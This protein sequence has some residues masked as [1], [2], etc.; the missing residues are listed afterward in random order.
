MVTLSL[1]M[2]STP[3]TIEAGPFTFNLREVEYDAEF[4]SGNLLFED[5]LN[6]P[7]PADSFTPAR[8]PGLF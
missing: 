1:V 2:A 5:I 6:E 7:F 3:D 4:V 8:F